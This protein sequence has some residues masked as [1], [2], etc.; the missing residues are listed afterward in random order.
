M[1]ALGHNPRQILD[2][3]RQAN[4]DSQ[5]IPRDI[6]NLL[7]GLRVEELSGKTPVEWLLQVMSL[8]LSMTASNNLLTKPI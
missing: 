3:L 8:L 6:Y 2:K 1:S 7:A 5:L 4:Q